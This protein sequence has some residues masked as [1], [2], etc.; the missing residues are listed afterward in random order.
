MSSTI[1][2]ILKEIV[3]KIKPE[4]E[5]SDKIDSK[6]KDFLAVLNKNLKKKNVNAGVFVGG[7][8]AKGTMIKKEYYDIDVFVRFD[9]KHRDRDISKTLKQALVG[10]KNVQEIHGS[11]NYYRV[12]ANGSVF[13]E[14]IPV[15]KV[16]NPKDA[17]NITDLSY[18]HV[19]YINKRI[20]DKKILDEIRLAKAFC[21]ANNVYGAESYISGF[22]GYGLELLVHHYKTFFNF[23]K[24]MT[25]FNSNNKEKLIIDIEKHY[26]NKKDVLLD[27]NSAKLLSPIILIDPTYRQRNVLA[28]LSEE[29][30]KQF[31]EACRQFI[32]T[33][34]AKAFEIKKLDLEEAIKSKGIKIELK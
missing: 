12:R 33:P 27:V 4:K 26:K 1:N 22:S 24:A 21:H 14:V 31:Q 7:S 6:L 34:S 30:F 29:T 23:I 3:D 2:H 28:A 32:K 11:R 18:F 5:D 8:Q 15:L 19:T 13:I 9:K 25:K 17:E 20:K 10:V 16:T